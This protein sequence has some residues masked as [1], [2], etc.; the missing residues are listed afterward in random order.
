MSGRAPAFGQPCRLVRRRCASRSV[1][2][3]RKACS[4]KLD[5][6]WP[7]GEVLVVCDMTGN[8]RNRR[9]PAEPHRP[10]CA[11]GDEPGAV[12]PGCLV[13]STAAPLLLRF[14]GRRSRNTKPP[15]WRSPRRFSVEPPDVLARGRAHGGYAPSAD[16][17]GVER[18]DPEIKGG[19]DRATSSASGG[20]ASICREGRRT[21]AADVESPTQVS[22]M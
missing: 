18:I 1:R 3:R 11:V 19:L 14:P 15:W 10:R 12:R 5:G 9:Q 4:C 16:V 17:G 8:R 7:R 6:S 21:P 13:G 2:G 22:L 20:Y